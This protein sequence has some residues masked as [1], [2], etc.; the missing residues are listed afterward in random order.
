MTAGGERHELRTSDVVA[1]PAWTWHELHAADD[2]LVVFRM[3][4]RPLQDAVGLYRAE[5]TAS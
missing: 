4:D 5:T 3:S 1:L 2:E